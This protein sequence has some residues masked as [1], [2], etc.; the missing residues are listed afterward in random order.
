MTFLPIADRELRV[1]ARSK[2]NHRLR[3]WFAIGAFAV[4]AAIGLFFSTTS[5][6]MMGVQVGMVIF[7]TLKW[8]GFIYAG[9]A[10]IFLTADCLS[11]EKRDGTLGL[12]FLTDLRGHDV[13]LG[14]L[15]ATSLRGFYSLLA[16]FP[17]MAFSFVLGGVAADDFAHT[18]VSICNTLFFSL[19]LGMFISVISRDPNKAMTGTMVALGIFVMLI[20]HIPALEWSSPVFAFTNTVLY[21]TSPFWYSIL[22]VN[23]EGWLLLAVASWLAP[24]TWQ[25]KGFRIRFRAGGRI[26]AKAQAAR[27]SLRDK[28]PVCWI[29]SRDRWGSVLAKVALLLML[30]LFVLSLISLSQPLGT[31]IPAGATTVSTTTTTTTNGQTITTSYSSSTNWTAGRNQNKFFMIVNWCSGVLP[32][33]IDFWLAAQV[34]RFYVDGRKSGFL[35]LLCVTPIRPADVVRGHWLAL[36][37]LFL[38]PVVAQFVL[39]LTLGAIEFYAAYSASTAPANVQM[40]IIQA[41]M[42]GL[43]A[44]NW[45]LGLFAV[46]WFSIWMGMTSKKLNIVMIKTFCYTKVLPYFGITILSGF[47][48][49]FAISSLGGPAW[50]WPLTYQGLFM[51]VNIALIYFARSFVPDAFTKWPDSAGT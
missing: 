1:S 40:A 42:A 14:K 50:L 36:R 27:R 2:A 4:A 24:Q 25:D 33:V 38:A 28:S 10:G 39:M 21:R 11:E 19:A 44:I 35:E 22:L 49:M 26:P 20:P 9:A 47:L 48:V 13:V 41:L 5:G 31:P 37:R 12:L 30:G 18:I 17:V 34:A 7:G 51:M 23:L 15:F 8:M 45:C 3:I 16:I 6:K 32:I 43:G 46:A 29:I